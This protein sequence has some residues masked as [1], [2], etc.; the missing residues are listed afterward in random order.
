MPRLCRLLIV[1]TSILLAATPSHA[2]PDSCLQSIV[3]FAVKTP[4]RFARFSLGL[5][6]Q[7]MRTSIT[8]GDRSLQ[9]M[10][11]LNAKS[12]ARTA[13]ALDR[14]LA[15]QQASEASPATEFQP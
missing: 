6:G 2:A 12:C 4:Q 7:G 11:D 15:D 1:S 10:L 5:K 9:A 14:L 3:N 13:I 8:G